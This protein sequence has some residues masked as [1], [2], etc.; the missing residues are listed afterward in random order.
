[1]AVEGYPHPRF[2]GGCR[3]DDELAA[4]GHQSGFGDAQA[5]NDDGGGPDRVRGAARLERIVD[6]HPQ[7][8]RDGE[9]HDAGQQG[10]Q[11]AHKK[12]GDD[13]LHV[14]IKTAD[15]REE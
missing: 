12:P 6:Q 11:K 14:G 1:M 10:A 7:H 4:E 3:V 2:H 9:R 15:G 5:Q 13:R 8:L